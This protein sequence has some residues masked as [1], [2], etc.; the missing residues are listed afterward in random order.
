[1]SAPATTSK[2]V[3]PAWAAELRNPPAHRSKQ[4]GIPDPPGFPSSHTPSSSK[5]V[6][7][8]PT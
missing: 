8:P 1:M 3:M 6:P 7:N 4:A 2:V 5:V